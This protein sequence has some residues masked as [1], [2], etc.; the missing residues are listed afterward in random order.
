VPATD[1][2]H[3]IF[4]NGVVE[5]NVQLVH[6]HSVDG[7]GN[8][9]VAFFDPDYLPVAFEP[10]AVDTP[11]LWNASYG[12]SGLVA[13][14]NGTQTSAD[15]SMSGAAS[16]ADTPLG[17]GGFD[18]DYFFTGDV[19]EVLFFSRELSSQERDAVETYLEARWSIGITP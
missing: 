14:T 1:E 11:Y 9:A 4:V 18:D 3:I 8:S 13:Y 19:G 5:C 12:S 7:Y 6:G 17:L 15:T 16:D 10:A 2:F